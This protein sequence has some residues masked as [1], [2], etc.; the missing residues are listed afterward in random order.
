[1]RHLKKLH[2]A[3]DAEYELEVSAENPAES[4]DSVVQE[5]D[6]LD[7]SQP[8]VL[9]TPIFQALGNKYVHEGL[10]GELGVVDWTPSTT[11]PDH[12]WWFDYDFDPS[13]LD[14]SLFEPMAFPE[15][16]TPHV[17][18]DE[19]LHL[20]PADRTLPGSEIQ[21]ACFT[22]VDHHRDPDTLQAYPSTRT[23]N[24]NYELDEEFRM[25]ASQK[26]KNQLTVDPLPSTG[27]LVSLEKSQNYSFSCTAS[28]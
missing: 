18:S 6:G 2:N 23:D 7:G 25:R 15:P 22:Y 10:V 26:L 13:A 28:G 11:F 12:S 3:P 19:M 27:L 1:M 8:I 16:F 4:L 17:S 5:G 20:P 9:D 24:E 14:M 21:K